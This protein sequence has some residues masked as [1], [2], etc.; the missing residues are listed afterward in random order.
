MTQS[1]Q[2][3]TDK[4]LA[5]KILEKDAKKITDTDIAKV[6]EQTERI[7]KKFEQ[8]TTLRRF[9]EDARL[10]GSMI[11]DYWHGKYKKVPYWAIASVAAALLYV[12][13]PLDLVPDFIVGFGLLDDAAVF[14]ACL[15]MVEKQLQAYQIWKAAQSQDEKEKQP[16]R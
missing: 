9:L 4:S 15:G 7:N 14:A 13:N 10:I 8:S 12:L 16:V 6:V 2:D 11:A 3:K 1:P 5:G